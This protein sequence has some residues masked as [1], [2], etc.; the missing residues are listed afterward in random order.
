MAD[1]PAI[2]YPHRKTTDGSYV[3]ICMRCLATVARTKAESRLEELEK[4]H[5]CY[6]YL[7]TQRGHSC[8]A[9]SNS[10]ETQQRARLTSAALP[11]ES[12]SP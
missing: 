1:K 7:V 2:F 10:A 3:S 9:Y 6:S 5:L 11:L 4:N 8:R 12:T